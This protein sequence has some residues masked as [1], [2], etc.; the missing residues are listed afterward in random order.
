MRS[1]SFEQEFIELTVEAVD[2]A[3]NKFIGHLT[4]SHKDY[5][6]ATEDRFCP[7]DGTYAYYNHMINSGALATNAP[8][9]DWIM[10]DFDAN[11]RMISSTR[12]CLDKNGKLSNMTSYY[13]RTLAMGA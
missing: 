6:H 12:K 2:L 3:R 10:A 1:P 7:N 5:Y 13:K 8:G 11:G 4:M 9:Q